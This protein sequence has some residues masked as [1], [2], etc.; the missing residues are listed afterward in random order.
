MRAATLRQPGLSYPRSTA[1]RLIDRA[2]D[3]L[4]SDLQTVD[5]LVSVTRR[6][7]ALGLRVAATGEE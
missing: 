4:R 3:P 1:F 5:G 2:Q 7:W 6:A